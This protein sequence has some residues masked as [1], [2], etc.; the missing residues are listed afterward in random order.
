MS[1]LTSLAVRL[2]IDRPTS[3]LY[4]YTSL[5]SIL[6]IVPTSLLHATDARFL[7]D[8]SEM[9]VIVENLKFAM[10]NVTDPDDFTARVHAELRA[11]LENRLSELGHAVF[12]AC[13][14]QNG[15]LLSQWRSYCDPGKGLSIGFNPDKLA[16]TAQAQ[17]FTVGKCIYDPKRQKE[18]AAEVLSVIELQAKLMFPDA[19]ERGPFAP[20]F[21]AVEA[22]LLNIAVLFKDNAFREEDEWRVVSPVISD[23]VNSAINFREG[24]S[25]LTP[26]VNFNLPTSTKGTVDFEHVWL[27]PTPHRNAALVAV[28][29]YFS[30]HGSAPRLGIGYCNIPYRT[31]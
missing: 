30:R 11:W 10:S 31:W 12:V 21:A 9:R 17:G 24:R 19:A 14:T 29:E 27:G 25:L 2:Y 26:Y 15:N 3:N 7:T 5:G 28:T 1:S 4:H 13:F 20:A 16:S 18:I 22:D 8:A 6:K 23:Y